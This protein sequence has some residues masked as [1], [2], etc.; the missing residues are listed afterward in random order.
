VFTWSGY[1]SGLV[2]A[3][4]DG[5]DRDVTGDEYL[6]GF[7]GGDL[8]VELT[9]K[10]ASGIL[11]YHNYTDE[12]DWIDA[13]LAG[14]VKAAIAVTKRGN[15]LIFS[16]KLP[17]RS[18]QLVG[19]PV[20]ENRTPTRIGLFAKTSSDNFTVTSYEYFTLSSINPFTDVE[21]WMLF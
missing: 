8:R 15:E 16:A 10:G 9:N 21:G 6:F 11:Q 14:N 12:Y 17:G 5:A 20:T 13:V 4:N 7:Y 3:Y 2:V 19:A 18:W 1:Q